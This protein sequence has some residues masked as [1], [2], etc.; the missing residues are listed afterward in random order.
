M[1]P[2]LLA[3]T[4]LALLL[5]CGRTTLPCEPNTC[6]G[7]CD[8]Y[9]NCQPG[10]DD[11][12]CG[13]G[14]RACVICARGATCRGGLCLGG[15]AAGAGGGVSGGGSAGG[16]GGGGAP[17]GGG[18]GPMSIGAKTYL[19]DA[20]LVV[21][22]SGSMAQ[23]LNP[24]D[25]ACRACAPTCPPSCLTRGAAMVN[26]LERLLSTSPA[27]A[28]FGLVQYPAN[29]SCGPP[30]VA[31][32]PLP[33]S[34]D[35]SV[36]AMTASAALTQLR[37]ATFSG[38][39]PTGPALRFAAAQ[40]QLTADARR[41]HFLVLVTDGL[42][43]CN[44]MNPATCANPQDCRCTISTCAGMNCTIGCLDRQNTL[45][46]LAGAAGRD[47]RTLVIA[48]STEVLGS[49]AAVALF[50]ELA[51]AGAAP[52]SCNPRTGNECGA[53]NPCLVDGT[54]TRKFSTE[55]QAGVGRVGEVLRRS[56]ACRWVLD[57]PVARS[58]RLVVQVNGLAVANGAE[59]F[60]AEADDVVR[61]SGAVCSQLA[62]PGA[63]LPVS[64]ALQP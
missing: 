46:A 16:A 49:M 30:T 20:L 54:C 60:V 59:G 47:V 55:L 44:P 56:G 29:A 19:P 61:F 48:F 18:A 42:P 35:P 23:P 3:P 39:T 4:L 11:L 58:P 40:P 24:N 62:A 51:R 25:P 26:A 15:T 5:S 41:E 1:K 17:S 33:M 45:D 52:L 12:E 31:S 7:C 27:P 36:L 38:G 64:F 32:P 21:D 2:A 57:Q 50:D 10:D 9:G 13:A 37:V 6:S 53:N 34:D 63:A 14:A 28:R 43:N 22:R 8:G